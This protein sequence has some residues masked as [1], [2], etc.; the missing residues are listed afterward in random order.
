MAAK[1]FKPLVI[2]ILLILPPA[3]PLFCADKP[4]AATGVTANT[5]VPAVTP[6]SAATPASTATAAADTVLL[7]QAQGDGSSVGYY[8]DTD[9]NG[10]SVFTQ[11]LSW[12]ADPYALRFEVIIRDSLGKEIFHKTTESSSIK[13]QLAPDTYAYNII[14]WNL[15]E[16]PEEESG[17][18]PLVVIKAELPKITGISPAFIYMDAPESKIVLKGEKLEEGATILL[19][20][21]SGHNI[22]ATQSLYA[23][24]SEVTATFPENDYKPGQFDIVV[25]NPGG[26]QSTEKNAIKIQYQRPVDILISVGYSPISFFQDSWFKSNWNEPM[27]WLGA[28]ANLTVYFVKKG[29][30]FLGAEAFAT[31]YKLSGGLDLASISSEYLLTGGNFLYRYRFN[32]TISAIAHAGGGIALSHHS[33]DYSGTAGPQLTASNICMDGGLSAQYFFPF[34]MY[35]ELGASWYEIFGTGYTAGGLSPTLRVGYQIF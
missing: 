5:G 32:K 30:G 10:N 19:R 13:V 21:S 31:G 20:D 35:V 17:W 33:F 14:T 28:N 16:Q 8:F 12:E 25:V 27:Y 7:D 24:N 6:A 23:G 3:L 18:Q 9:A 22:K 34:K 26:L 4:A 29:W 2:A 11:V 15:L 1:T